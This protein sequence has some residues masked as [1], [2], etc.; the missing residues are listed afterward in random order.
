MKKLVSILLA[1]VTLLALA[2]PAMAVPKVFIT[3]QTING[4]SYPDGIKLAA[5]KTLTI[6]GTVENLRP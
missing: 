5:G 2:V 4:G 1:L 6:E 3:N